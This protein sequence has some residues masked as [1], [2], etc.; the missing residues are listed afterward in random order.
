MRLWLLVSALS[1][2]VGLSIGAAAEQKSAPDPRISSIN[3]FGAGIGKTYRGIVRGQNLKGAHAIEVTGGGVNGRVLRVEAEPASEPNSKGGSTTYLVEV[4]IA[5]PPAAEPGP[6]QL[7]L[8]TPNGITNAIPITFV[9]E[10]LL[11]ETDVKDT[12]PAFPL[13]IAGSISKRGEVDAFWFQAIAG[14]TLTLQ[15]SSG[16]SALDLSL[17]IFEPAASWF[18]PKH[19]EQIA[20]ND[21]PLSFPGL[22]TEPRITHTFQKAGRYCLKVQSSAGQGSPDAVYQVRILPGGSPAQALHPKLKENSWEERQFTR[23]LEDD[24][25]NQLARRGGVSIEPQPVETYRAVSL[26]SHEPPP[27]MTLPGVVEGTVS[28]PAEAHRIK[29]RIEKPENLAIEI[30]T[31]KATMPRFNPVILIF[32]PGGT[33]VATNVYTKRNNNGLY[34]MK[35]IQSKVTLALQAPGAYEMEIRDITTD[36]AGA[37]FRYRVLVRRQ[38]PHIGKLEVAEEKINLR[39]GVAR[40]IAISVEREEGFNGLITFTVE[41]LPAGVTALPAAPAPSDKPPLPNGGKLERYVPILQNAALVFVAAPDAAVTD[42]PSKVRILARPVVNGKM[43]ETIVVKELPL[44]VLSESI[45]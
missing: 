40:D 39:R 29:L 11:A 32:E 28:H 33:E 8:L 26:A 9:A 35:M 21:E 10:P 20:Y 15:A 5:C 1:I 13:T 30:E 36:R 17:G 43:G 3:P 18:D 27:I 22:S 19:M 23:G 41:G 24:R 16:H 25:H 44:M 6:R 12:L 31:S 38:I 2:N 4:E 34:M 7:R 42:V 37:D 45:P 14:Q